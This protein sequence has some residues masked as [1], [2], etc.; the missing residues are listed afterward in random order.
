MTSR[1]HPSA[2]F[3]ATVGTLAL[4]CTFQIVGLA[5]LYIACQALVAFGRN[6][7]IFPL[8]I[9]G[10]PVSLFGAIVGTIFV[11]RWIQRRFTA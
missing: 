1:K 3:W 8:W 4:H 10:F 2:A 9:A 6:D 5:I 7:W 11:G